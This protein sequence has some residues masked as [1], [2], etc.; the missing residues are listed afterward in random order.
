MLGLLKAM[1]VSWMG[2][3]MLY[4]LHVPGL[5]GWVVLGEA[6]DKVHSAE[7]AWRFGHLV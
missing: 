1:H 2:T 6:P 3:G 5:S 4:G 7:M